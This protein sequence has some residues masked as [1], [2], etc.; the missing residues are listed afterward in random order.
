VVD[1][2]STPRLKQ[3]QTLEQIATE[4]Q[5]SL[6]L[7]DGPIMQV[8]MFNLG[9]DE[10][11][12]LLIII[13]HLAVDGV[14]WRILLS[15]LETIYQQLIAQQPIKLS[16]KTTAYIDWAEK[17][18][19][20]AQSQIIKQQLDYWLKQPWS[21]TKP[22]PSDYPQTQSENTVGSAINYRVNLNQQETRSLLLSVNEAYNT[23]INDI[24]LSALVLTL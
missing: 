3:P 14:S 13:H 21:K 22:L 7:S 4:Y 12:R 10:D 2:S 6:N 23:Q 18:N 19:N 9:V 15:D 5:A 16:P 24:L 11:A 1:L 17:L 20:Y 8:V